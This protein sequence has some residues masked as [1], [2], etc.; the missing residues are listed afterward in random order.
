MT[1]YTAL[2]TAPEMPDEEPAEMARIDAD[3]DR[4]P[5]RPGIM[6]VLL[7]ALPM[8]GQI[9]HYMKDLMPLWA[10]SKAFPVLSLPLGLVLFA[11]M[12]VPMTRQ[13]MISF[14]W[15]S[16]TPTFAAIFY[17]NQD[18]FTGLSAQVKLLPM[19]YFFS[20]LGLLLL[21][22]PSLRE[23][24]AGFLICGLATFAALLLLTAIVPRS[25]Y[26]GHYQLGS[27]EGTLFSSDDRGTRIRMPM[28]FGIV[29]IFYAYRRFLRRPAFSSLLVAAGGFLITL[30]IVKTRAMLVGMAGVIAINAVLKARG[31]ARV[32]VILSAPVSLAALFSTGYLASMFKTDA[33]SGFALRW[34]T[35]LKA[36]RFL[37]VDPTRWILGVGTIS[38]T[39]KDSL[40]AFF[41]HFFFLADIT[42]LGIIFEFGIVGAVLFLLY[43]LRGIHFY[44]TALKPR[45]HSDFLGSLSDY[46]LYVLL[47]SNL[48]PPSL[49]PGETAVILAIF[50]YV[51]Q[52]FERQDALEAE[53]P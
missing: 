9:F 14:L 17:F 29:T 27:A 48:Y 20:F 18:F 13:V 23:L 21:L 46:L 53:T 31:V 52:W 10:F 32:L 50:A 3:A 12:R 49:T 38:P 41:D 39:N 44:H 24:K 25:W 47:I 37:G 15:L 28:Y 51:W 43:E 22:Q 19:L 4:E 35:V 26:S 11:H 33:S 45:L 7:M 42:W 30:W 6:A 5:L 34:T 8:F 1:S 2:S 16:L 40:A 36:S